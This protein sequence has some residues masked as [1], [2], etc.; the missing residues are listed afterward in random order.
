LEEFNATVA[1]ISD[2]KDPENTIIFNRHASRPSFVPSVKLPSAEALSQGRAGLNSLESFYRSIKSLT[3]E[4]SAVVWRK[5]LGQTGR[6][7]VSFS[8][9][10]GGRYWLSVRTDAHLN[11]A[12]DLEMSFDGANSFVFLHPDK[13]LTIHRNRSIDVVASAIP[14]PFFL[15]LLFLTP[16]SDSCP[17]CSLTLPESTD[18]AAWTERLSSPRAERLKSGAARLFISGRRH[19]EKD[20]YFVMEFD[21]DG[22]LVRLEERLPSGNPVLSLDLAAYRAVPGATGE[23]PVHLTLTGYAH[24]K[25]LTSVMYHVQLV[26]VNQH[27]TPLASY[28]IDRTKA[29]IVWDASQRKF[30]KH[31]QVW[32]PEEIEK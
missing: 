15:P 28:A 12:P 20:T 32:P 19:Q 26:E 13:L 21:R 10:N 9:E 24:G 29:D 1:S 11:L 6:G 3:F 27:A 7:H 14:N 4:A 23:F 17:A 5:D 18:A 16:E 22:R 30:L 31:Y 25:A 8:A 2:N